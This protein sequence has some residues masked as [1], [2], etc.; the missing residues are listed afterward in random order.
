MTSRASFSNQFRTILSS[1]FSRAQEAQRV[2]PW[3]PGL[4]VETG[5]RIESDGRVYISAI[6]GTTSSQRP[7]HSAGIV[8]G[9][10]LLEDRRDLSG[11][12]PN[13]YIFVGKPSEWESSDTVIED[14]ELSD[15][16]QHQIISDIIGLKKLRRSDMAFCAQ[17]FDWTA[18]E[19]Y[20]S[21]T[22]DGPQQLPFYVMTE[23]RNIYKCLDN[24]SGSPSTSEPNGTSATPVLYGDGYV[25]KYMATIDPRDAIL[26]MSKNLMPLR[27]KTTDD[28]SAQYITQASAKSQGV[29]SF[30][31]ISRTQ[32]TDFQNPLYNI[33]GPGINCSAYIVKN[34]GSVSQVIVSN[35]G[36]GYYSGPRM[37]VTENGA[38]GSGFQGEALVSPTG[39]ISGITILSN[40]SGYTG[41]VSAFIVGD[42]EGAEVTCSVE[43][44][45]ITAIN[46][47]SIGS[48][49]TSAEV[50]VI[51]GTRGV[52]AE[53]VLSPRRGHGSNVLE[54]LNA[55]IISINAIIPQN[56]YFPDGLPFRR[57]GILSG[58]KDIAG[59]SMV[60]D[61]YSGPSGDVQDNM[62]DERSGSVVYVNNIEKVE[63]VYGQED[64]LKIVIPF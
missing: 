6:V 26:F 28:G 11:I 2:L 12:D 17:R 38:P 9:L 59:N 30:R 43:L 19:Y 1:I 15:K 57:I 55:S 52:I 32:D 41:G 29:S 10:I 5:S 50:V 58:G 56:S 7:S 4:P 54:E 34:L 46:I 45:I 27:Y 8:E 20:F 18:G 14:A 49:Y 13:L 51:P 35:P 16:H 42:G 21:Y 23:N 31:I 60:E 48:G 36:T 61:Y 44:G 64:R 47:V 39:S 40:G 33:S 3:R 24:N 53:G 22:D 63:R 62:Y 37:I 25:W